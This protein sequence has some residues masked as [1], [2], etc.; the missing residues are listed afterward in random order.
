MHKAACFATANGLSDA[1]RRY[2]G[3][4]GHIASRECLAEGH[5]VGQDARMLHRKHTPRTSEACGYLVEDEQHAVLIAQLTRLYEV[6][7]VVEVH[8]SSSLHDRL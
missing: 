5:N 6:V 4:E 3:G 1:L 8:T 2:N 7:G